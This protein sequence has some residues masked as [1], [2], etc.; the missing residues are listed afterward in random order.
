[1]QEFTRQKQPKR[2]WIFADSNSRRSHCIAR[3][4]HYPIF[5]GWLKTQLEPRECNGEDELYEALYEILISLSIEMIEMIEM[6]FA[7]WINRLQRL[8]KGNGDY[9][10]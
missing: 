4:L 8:I 5:F 7:D 2:N 1:M 9:I 3:R 10:S 6:V